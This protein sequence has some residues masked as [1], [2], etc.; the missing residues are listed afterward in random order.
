MGFVS[1]PSLLLSLLSLS[2]FIYIDM[3]LWI[4]IYTLGYNPMLHYF[5]A[6][7]I[8][9]SAIGS[10]IGC[11]I[12]YC[13][14]ILYISASSLEPTTSPRNPGFF[15]WRISLE[16]RCGHWVFLS[17]FDLTGPPGQFLDVRSCFFLS[18]KASLT[19]SL[20]IN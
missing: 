11:S 8:P 19:F 10:S 5:V 20:T 15:Y 6:Q 9:A 17:N 4:F 13:R 12:L 16:V 7:I 18:Q 2:S 3:D 14:H 1:P